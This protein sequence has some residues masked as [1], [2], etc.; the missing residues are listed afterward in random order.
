MLDNLAYYLYLIYNMIYLL[1]LL[2]QLFTAKVVI[3]VATIVTII[4]NISQFNRFNFIEQSNFLNFR[5]YFLCT[6]PRLHL[7]KIMDKPFKTLLLIHFR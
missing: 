7:V 3:K 1:F 2:A 6:R 5:Y 4:V